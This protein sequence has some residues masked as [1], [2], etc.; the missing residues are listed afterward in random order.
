MKL[1]QAVTIL[2]QGVE[3]ATQKGAYARTDVVTLDLALRVLKAAHPEPQ[4]KPLEEI[5]V[6]ESK[7]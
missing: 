4:K 1:E 2:E 6:T 5:E 3:I 7:D